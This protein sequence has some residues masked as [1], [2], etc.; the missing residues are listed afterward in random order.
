ML[1]RRL[2]RLVLLAA[3]LIA[4]L[5]TP[6]LISAHPLA[7]ALLELT[8]AEGGVDVTWKRSLAGARKAPVDPVLPA[9]CKELEEPA[10]HQ[11]KDG[12]VLRWRVDC[13]PE[14]LV[15][16]R[17]TVTGLGSAKIDVLLRITLAD[18]R[19]VGGVLRAG[20]T[21]YV[22]PSRAQVTDVLLD[23]GRLGV[24]HILSGFDHLVFVFG[25]L[26][27]AHGLRPLVL[28]ITCFTLGH[29]VTL[30]LAALGLA[31]FPS[32]PIEV[33]ISASILVLAVELAREKRHA[34]ITPFR[35]WPW[36]LSFL[37]GLLH[38][39]GFAGALREVGLPQEEIVAALFSFNVGIEIGQLSFVVGV[40]VLY[41]LLRS[42]LANL[43]MWTRWVPVYAMG[44]LSAMWCFERVA[45]WLG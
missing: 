43:P 33:A 23:Y 27:L 13:G 21:T 35:R 40:L 45:D 17:I 26:L 1:P 20:E 31:K 19:R 2:C 44:S 9:E 30:S 28:T 18:G 3:T 39:L 22:V 42:V 4:V 41:R 8:E 16:K 32:A 29:S 24:T 11:V 34:K 37:F 6:Q 7:P 36:L 38:G 5:A 10:L 15:G 12:V 25:L 14:G